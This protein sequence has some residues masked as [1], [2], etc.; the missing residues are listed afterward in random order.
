MERDPVAI[1]LRM[2]ESF[3]SELKAFIYDNRLIDSRIVQRLIA[4]SGYDSYVK[5]FAKD[6]IIVFYLDP[7]V[8]RKKC[9]YEECS[10]AGSDGARECLERCIMES[11]GEISRGLASSIREL[12]GSI[13][14]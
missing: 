11:L 9:L 12:A 1:A 6:H 10:E 7:A 2:A 3:E 13:E 4:L 8:V 5:R 14:T